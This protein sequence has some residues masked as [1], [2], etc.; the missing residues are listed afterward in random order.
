VDPEA[1]SDLR[2]DPRA[3]VLASTINNNVCRWFDQYKNRL[4]VLGF[5]QSGPPSVYLMSLKTAPVGRVR[6]EQAIHDTVLG[7]RYSL[8]EYLNRACNCSL[9][10]RVE[11][12]NT[13]GIFVQSLI[14]P[15][16]YKYM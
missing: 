14:N 11:F 16:D 1:N 8:F 4:L 15:P 9:Y 12:H 13:V 2:L 10:S 3:A 6:R 5:G 7:T